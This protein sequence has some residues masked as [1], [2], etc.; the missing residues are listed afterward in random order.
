M[1]VIDRY[2]RFVLEYL[3]GVNK[4]SETTMQD[5]FNKYNF[6]DIHSLPGVRTD[7]YP[8]SPS[9]VR[10]TEF[11]GGVAEV[12]L[13]ENYP[14]LEPAQDEPSPADRSPDVSSSI[15]RRRTRRLPPKFEDPLVIRSKRRKVM[16][17]FSTKF[18]YGAILFVVHA[19]ILF[20]SLYYRSI[21]KD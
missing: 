4:T 5:L 15:P 18:E 8:R 12:S 20:L 13:E 2:T 16:E 1:A 14:G 19:P 17:S 9:E 7:L 6:D 11:F 10:L 21:L 3:E